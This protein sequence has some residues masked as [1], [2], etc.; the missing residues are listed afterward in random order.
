MQKITNVSTGAL[1][2]KNMLNK[3]ISCLHIHILIG[4]CLL[5]DF[6]KIKNMLKN[7]DNLYM[8]MNMFHFLP[9]PFK[10]KVK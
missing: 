9:I 2:V 10:G 3:R 4:T 1:P 6:I 5:K 7:K 8:R